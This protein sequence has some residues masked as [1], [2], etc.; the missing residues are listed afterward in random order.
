MFYTIKYSKNKTRMVHFGL[1]KFTNKGLRKTDQ[2]NMNNYLIIL[3]MHDLISVS[4]AQ[5]TCN[6][7]FYKCFN[8]I[9]IKNKAL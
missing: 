3:K 5:K 6:Y 9:H 4:T 1:Y 8:I 2:F 7:N